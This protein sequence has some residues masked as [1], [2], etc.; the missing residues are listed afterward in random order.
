VK[1]S[2]SFQIYNAEDI[3]RSADICVVS[4]H[5]GKHIGAAAHFFSLKSP[6]NH[7]TTTHTANLPACSSNADNSFFVGWYN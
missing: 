7:A 6:S 1:V 5:R 3:K 4:A 2:N